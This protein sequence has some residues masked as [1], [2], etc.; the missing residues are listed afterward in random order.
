VSEDRLSILLVDD[1]EDDA[2]LVRDFLDE[3]LGADGFVLEHA[4]SY[5]AGL[6]ALDGGRHG[7]C[8]FDL[9]LGARTGLDLMAEARRR[10]LMVP[11][12]ILTGQGDEE[13]AAQ[14]IKEGASDY[15]P[16]VRLDAERLGSAIRH[17]LDL[18]AAENEARRAQA[19]KERLI[20]EL[21]EALAKVK[22]L[23]G[24]IP[25]CAHCKK[26]RDDKGYW[27]QVDSYIRTHSDAEIS[28]G[29]CPECAR[30]LYPDLY[31]DDQ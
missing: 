5:Q 29:I 24:L 12:V 11:V 15:L 14:A 2:F 7:L 23:S 26:I 6:D 28:H 27:Q 17:A 8:L 10:G 13:I 21:K 4:E 25:L 9:R 3:A 16:K 18:F 22:T 30:L 20:V 19:E 1:D 31:P